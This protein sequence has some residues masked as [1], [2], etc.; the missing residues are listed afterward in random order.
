MHGD[1]RVDIK[2]ITEGPQIYEYPVEI[3]REELDDAVLYVNIK[4][5]QREPKIQQG[6]H[7]HASIEYVK[8][9]S[10]QCSNRR[11]IYWNYHDRET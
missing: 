4:R 2:Q 5:P 9:N 11:R 8:S 10:G 6:I 3:K 1:Q 7:A